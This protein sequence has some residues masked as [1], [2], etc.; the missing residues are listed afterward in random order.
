M[1]KQ[2]SIVI[3]GLAV[4][5]ILKAHSRLLRAKAASQP[6]VLRLVWPGVA[7]GAGVLGQVIHPSLPC[8]VRVGFTGQTGPGN[9]RLSEP[10]T[11]CQIVKEQHDNPIQAKMVL[12]LPFFLMNRRKI[13][14]K[15]LVKYMIPFFLTGY[16][17]GF[18]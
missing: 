17:A 13:I 6:L 8:M 7:T 3:H 14:K 11:D 9:F 18:V 4:G 1:V 15:C 5:Y 2:P 16:K 12:F 10:H